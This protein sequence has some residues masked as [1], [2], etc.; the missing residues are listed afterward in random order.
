MFLGPV[1]ADIESRGHFKAVFPVPLV[2]EFSLEDS[3]AHIH[4]AIPH[5]ALILKQL[6]RCPAVRDSRDRHAE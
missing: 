3:R 4:P 2:E 1:Y 5:H 6:P